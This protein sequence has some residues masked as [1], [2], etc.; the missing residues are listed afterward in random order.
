MVRG[1]AALRVLVCAWIGLSGVHC[2]Q[3]SQRYPLHSELG[4][5]SEVTGSVS[6][7]R[8]E[9]GER[10]VV[11]E[12]R[13]LPPPERLAPGLTDFVV[14]L[15]DPSGAHIKAGALRY[16]RAHQSGSLYATTTLPAFTVQV[17]GERDPAASEPSGVLLTQRK[18]AFNGSR[19]QAR[20]STK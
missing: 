2:V 19:A 9:G 13:E 17:T 8:V 7:E 12:L 3:A 15:A 1:S 6:V 14:W 16:D 4:G 20:A 5:A 11:V 10:L 18:V